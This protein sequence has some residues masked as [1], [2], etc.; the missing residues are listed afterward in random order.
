MDDMNNPVAGIKIAKENGPSI[1]A[2]WFRI[3]LANRAALG[4]GVGGLSTIHNANDR[5]ISDKA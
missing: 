2:V 1:Q 4:S 5:H 3:S